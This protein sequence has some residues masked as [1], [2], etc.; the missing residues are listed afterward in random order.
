MIRG[1][2]GPCIAPTSIAA[3]QSCVSFDGGIQIYK[4]WKRRTEQ[5]AV[6]LDNNAAALADSS[7]SKNMQVRI[8]RP[9]AMLTRSRP[10]VRSV[11]DCVRSVR[12]RAK[13]WNNKMHLE[14]S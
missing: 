13:R 4:T 5:I 10:V 7:D 9:A 8:G 6:R 12:D 2:G 11:P 14:I 3:F 1:R